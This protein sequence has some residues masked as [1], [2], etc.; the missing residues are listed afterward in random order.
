MYKR[1]IPDK[2]RQLVETTD[3]GRLSAPDKTKEG[4]EMYAVCDKQTVRSTEAAIQEVQSEI[5][6][7][8]GALF[9]RQY[10]RNLRKDAV[11]ERR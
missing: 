6:G 5:I 4:L 8:E 11:I 2:G 7:E 9:S 3:V 1:R 10:L